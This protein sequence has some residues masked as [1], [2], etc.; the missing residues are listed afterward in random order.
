MDILLQKATID[1]KKLKSYLFDIVGNDLNNLSEPCYQPK[2]K[3]HYYQL[4]HLCGITDQDIKDFVERF[5]EG[6][7]AGEKK[8]LLEQN[9]Y[10]NLLIVLMHYFLINND[11]VS[12]STTVIYYIITVYTNLMAIH[13]RYCNPDIF[14]YTLEHL[15]KTHL[16]TREKTIS[17]AIFH[18]AR[19]M[20]RRHTET[21]LNMQDPME[22]SAFIRECRTRMSQSVQSFRE[23]YYRVKEEGVGFKNQGEEEDEFKPIT[24][25]SAELIDKVVKKITMYKEIDR[26]ALDDA[27]QITKIKESLAT[28]IVHEMSDLKY[29]N[30]IKMILEL[31]TKDLKDVNSICSKEFYQYVK[32]LMSVKKTKQSVF[33]KQQ[34]T[35]LLVKIIEALN[36]MPKFKSLSPQTQ[37]FIAS[38]IAFYI[39]IVFR[40]FTC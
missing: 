19:E 14:R 29:S 5:Y 36:Y 18:M 39:T 2:I 23:L 3:I 25:R 27:R 7:P 9:P 37:F 10:T 21:F 30:N 11:Q 15:N 34:V 28:M 6:S 17:G 24:D 13:L 20:Q 33:F 4:L 35:E 38:F 26:K 8:W 31:F 1:H 12:Y 22:V 32:S 16:F 40:N